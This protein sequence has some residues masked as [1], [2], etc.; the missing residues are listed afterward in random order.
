MQRH[1][2]V[3][4]VHGGP[5]ASALLVERTFGDHQR[6][7]VGDGVVD[8]ETVAVGDEVD[9]LVEVPRRRRV[10]GDER[11]VGVVFAG[12]REPVDGVACLGERIVTVGL[13]D[14]EL[15]AD[16]GEVDVGGEEE[17]RHVW[18]PSARVPR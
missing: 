11:H 7:D 13:V 2:P 1:R 15:V 5:A 17:A 18:N 16:T 9:G 3:R 4:E 14:T 10:D 8:D 12:I 6:R